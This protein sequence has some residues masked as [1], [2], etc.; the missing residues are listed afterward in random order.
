MSDPAYYKESLYEGV[1]DV[2]AGAGSPVHPADRDWW[3]Q[4]QQQQGN[5][6]CESDSGSGSSQEINWISMFRAVEPEEP[7][8]KFF[9]SEYLSVGSGSED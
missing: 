2:R 4:Q 1:L 3:A 7:I 8:F 5:L 9:F 6:G